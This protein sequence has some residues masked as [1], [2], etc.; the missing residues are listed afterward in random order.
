MSETPLTTEEAPAHP[1]TSRP[2]LLL[3]LALLSGA[4]LLLEISLTRLLSTLYYPPTV[5]A[6]I[7]LALL[8]LGLGAALVTARVSWRRSRHAPT[9]A[10][11]AALSALLL[12]AFAVVTAPLSI[13]P[14]LL[15]LVIVPFLFMG[16]TFAVVFAEYS[17]A[18]PRLYLA[19]LAGAGLGALLAVPVLDWVG[20]VNGVV[21]AGLALGLAGWGLEI[22]EWRVGSGQA[23][24]RRFS[25]GATVALLGALVLVANLWTGFLTIDMSQLSSEKP[26]VESLA[27]EGETVATR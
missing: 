26:I 4:G 19:D 1:A 8:G 9:F 13:L 22:G 10:A 21:V 20:G 14:L 5:F 2:A 3:A 18:S 27:G 6:V 17:A 12:V 23:R 15:L 25:A 7:S 11:L 16:M 24:S